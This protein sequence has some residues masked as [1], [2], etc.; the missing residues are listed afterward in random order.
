MRPEYSRTDGRKEHSTGRARA[1]VCVGL[2]WRFER[3]RWRRAR[4][5]DEWLPNRPADLSVPCG[6]EHEGRR[7]ERSGQCSSV[8]RRRHRALHMPAGRRDGYRPQRHHLVQFRFLRTSLGRVGAEARHGV[9]AAA[10]LWC[11]LRRRP[12]DHWRRLLRCA[13]PGARL[14]A[15]P[16][17]C[18]RWPDPV[19]DMHGSEREQVDRKLPRDVVQLQLQRRAGLHV[20]GGE[21]WTRLLP[22]DPGSALAAARRAH[23]AADG[24]FPYWDTLLV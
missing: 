20:H 12:V 21:R 8:L 17:D 3:C 16:G 10:R 11:K 23:A 4:V 9:V 18:V 22:R 19:D 5:G 24:R 15:L 13:A 1:G 14:G 2:L 7:A 6:R